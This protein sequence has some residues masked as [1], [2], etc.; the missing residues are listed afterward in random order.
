MARILVPYTPLTIASTNVVASTLDEWSDASVSYTLG[1][2]VK[3][4]TGVLPHRE[5]EAKQT[6]TSSAENAPTEADNPYWI[7][8][9]ATNQHAMFDGF[10]NSRTVA[11]DPSG[12]IVVELTLTSRLQYLSLLGL[13]NCSSVTLTQTVD[14]TEVNSETH[15]LRTSWNPPGWWE[16]LFGERA[17]VRSFAT[18]LYGNYSSQTLTITLTGATTAEIA[19]C[20]VSSGIEVGCT[21]E[22]GRPRIKR[23][24]TFKTNTFGVYEYVPRKSTRVGNYMMVLDTPQVD[25]VF[26][27]MEDLEESG[28]LVV[29]DANNADTSFDCIRAY[30]AI[31]DFAPGLKYNKTRCDFKIEA[32]N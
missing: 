31:T 11:D 12:N 2:Q 19:Q 25:R 28:N 9:G 7:P 16:Y 14:G 24:S 26:A 20:L 3:V 17:Y 22:E 29:L 23:W 8:L 18:R 10:N 32:I 27:F 4:T 1:D 6:H 30:G 21:L 15:D 5:Y 13:R